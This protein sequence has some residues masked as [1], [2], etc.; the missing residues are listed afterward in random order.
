MKIGS[1]FFFNF[2]KKKGGFSVFKYNPPFFYPTILIIFLNN[3]SIAV[4]VGE[5]M[6]GMVAR[7]KRIEQKERDIIK[8][9]NKR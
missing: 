4:F 3:I 7:R 1:H 5:N 9:R 2:Y 8:M 6:F